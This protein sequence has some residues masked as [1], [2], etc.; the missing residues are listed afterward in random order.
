[1]Q[2]L[3][4]PSSSLSNDLG[5][6]F[7]NFKT[8]STEQKYQKPT[9]TLIDNNKQITNGKPVLKL[10]RVIFLWAKYPNSNHIFSSVGIK[11]GLRFN[12]SL[13]PDFHV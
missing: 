6:M 3:W 13:S 5:Y 11:D 4:L 12:Y 2:F 9:N 10:S 1:M 8:F 7:L